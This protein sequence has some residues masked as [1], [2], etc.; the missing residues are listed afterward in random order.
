MAVFEGIKNFE[1]ELN[2][3][4]ARLFISYPPLQASAFDM[5]DQQIKMVDSSLK[6]Y[7]FSFL[8]TPE[9]FKMPDSLL[10]DSPYHLTGKGG[11][12]RTLQLI[13]YLRKAGISN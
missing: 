6:K 2:K 7:N 11:E 4:G 13:T 1:I 3:K 12:L 8:G 5:A 10:F 9:D